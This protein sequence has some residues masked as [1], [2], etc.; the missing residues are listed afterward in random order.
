MIKVTLKP[1]K[2]TKNIIRFAEVGTAQHVGVIYVPKKTLEAMS[3]EP[4]KNLELTL[5][6]EVS[7]G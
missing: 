2:D 6:L 4:G 7:N 5:N 3:Y 1:D